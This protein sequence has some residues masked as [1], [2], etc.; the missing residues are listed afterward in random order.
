MRPLFLAL[1]VAGLTATPARAQLTPETAVAEM[2]RGINLGNTLEPP[3]EGAW[4]NGPVREAYF[5]AYKDA[6][7]ATV[8]IPVRWDEHTADAPPYAINASWIDRVEQ[9]VDWA[10]ERDL[11]VIL[12]AHH[13][14]W[15]KQNYADPAQRAR[16]DSIW[17]QVADRFQDKS[18]KLLF[19]IINEPFGMTREEVDDLNARILSIIRVENPTRLVIYSGNEYS[20]VAQLLA[21][22]VPDDDYIVAYFH[23]YD[24][25]E[26]AGLGGGTWG[27]A[28]QR[29]TVRQRFTEVAEW[30]ASTGVPVVISEFGAVRIA[31]ELSRQVFYATYVEEALRAG[32]AFQVWDDGGDFRIYNRVADTWPVELDLLIRA[33]PDG[34][35]DLRTTG[36]QPVALS[37]TLRSNADAVI[38]ERRAPQ[39]TFAEVGRLAGTATAFTDTTAVGGQTY[40]YRVVAETAARPRA[41]SYPVQVAA[42]P[43]VRSP[44]SGQPAPVPGTVEAE[45]FDA[46]G[47]GLTYHDTTPT[48]DPGA[49]RSDVAVDIEPR[50]GGGFQVTNTVAT[51]WLEYTVDVAEAGDYDVTVFAA[52]EVGGG[53]LRVSFGEAKTPILQVPTTADGQTLVPLVA[54]LSL[55]A[56]EQ[57][58][59]LD[60]LSARPYNL[61]R[62]EIQPSPLTAAEPGA[63]TG[64]LRIYPNPAPEW[65]TVETGSALGEGYLEIVTVLGRRVRQVA[66]RSERVLTVPVADL[67]PGTYLLRAF[68]EGRPVGQRVFVKP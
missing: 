67:A 24:P 26:F 3:R 68:V 50:T 18:E 66:F 49:Y 25:W 57:V 48:N 32:F 40:Q 22:A 52:A 53:R 51:E 23:S 47:E 44:F 55:P 28:A 13:E 14:D 17:V 42:L 7:F 43:T 4:N 45:D 2:G 61:D 41:V 60:V 34:P 27:T 35:T 36:D 12:N 29:A 37:W 58:M 31:D 56:G 62:I 38:V 65:L 16:F 20:N 54:T 8:R 10:L 64:A 46:G 15:L 6:G 33:Y 63:K 5:D 11:Y 21:A 19:E 9:V 30:S 1:L 59:R 39:G